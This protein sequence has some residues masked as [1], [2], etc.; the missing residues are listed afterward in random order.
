MVE[1][2]HRHIV[3]AGLYARSTL[4]SVPDHVLPPFDRSFV[5]M[6]RACDYE[7]VD[8]FAA[9]YNRW[10]SDPQSHFENLLQDSPEYLPIA[11]ETLEQEPDRLVQLSRGA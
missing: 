2:I 7:F 3:F 4:N 6:M 10:L 5:R 11:L 8:L 9:T 1:G